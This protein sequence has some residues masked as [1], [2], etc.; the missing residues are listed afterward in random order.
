MPNYIVD[1]SMTKVGVTEVVICEAHG[2][3]VKAPFNDKLNKLFKQREQTALE[4]DLDELQESPVIQG[5]EDS[6]RN[7]D[8]SLKKNPPTAESFFRNIQHRGSIPRINSIVD[9]YTGHQ[10]RKLVILIPR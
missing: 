5:Y 6:V 8:R 1:P 4:T 7:V 9:I 2:L 3:D 10:L